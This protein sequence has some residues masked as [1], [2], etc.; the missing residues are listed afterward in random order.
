[1]ITR[2]PARKS[3]PA[4][5]E[6]IILARS[7]RRCALCFHL[8]GDLTEKLGQIAH[9]D[10]DRSNSAEDNLAFMCLAHHSLFDSTTSQHKNYTVAEVKAARSKLYDYLANGKH[11]KS[12]ITPSS[13]TLEIGRQI[14]RKVGRADAEDLSP[15]E[16]ELLWN[17]VQAGELLHSTTFDGEAMRTGDR[18]FLDGVDARTAAEWLGA[19]RSLEN[20]GFVEPLSSDRD[21]FRVTD[22]GYE[23]AD[24]FEGFARWNANAIVLRAYDL[25]V[26]TREAVLS[27]TGIV[28]LP[29][30]FYPDQNGMDGS[31]ARS[32]KQPRSLL[33]E[34]IDKKA[35]PSWQPTDVEFR[36][37]S[38]GSIEQFQVGGFEIVRSTLKLGLVE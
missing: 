30:V 31:V 21:F 9:L 25:K 36:D 26:P 15:R 24:E 27:C 34:G 22:G 35:T 4:E 2:K 16:I 6:T 17:A 32:L 1:M 29:A 8:D 33:V 7:A 13:L 37:E 18:Q 23:A 19:L 38:T 11:L 10:G 20:R 3:T 12:A 14:I 28:A 5:I